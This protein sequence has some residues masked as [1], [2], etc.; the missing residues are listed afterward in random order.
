MPHRISKLIF[1][2]LLGK[3]LPTTEGVITIHGPERPIR[4]DRDRYGIPHIAAETDA[5]AWFALGFCQGQDR[6]FQI[7]ALVRVV[8]GTMSELIGTDMVPLDRLSRRIGFK[9]AAAA[10]WQLI[11][12]DDR[13]GLSAFAAGVNAGRDDGA[14]AKAHE[15]TLLRGG[16]TTFEATDVLAILALQAFA[17]AANW[18]AELARFEIL[19]GDGE[20]ALHKVDPKYPEWHP[21]TRSPDGMAGV[22]VDGLRA[23]LEL[24]REV[25]GL[26][27]ASN[28]WAI[29]GSRTTTGRPILANDPHLSPLLPPHWYL[30]HVSGVDWGVAG[31]CFAGTPGFASAH[32]GKVAWGVTAGLV[33]NTDLFIE[34]IGPDGASVQRGDDFVPCTV[35]EE[36][37]AVRGGDPVTEE[38]LMTP[39]G[40]IVGPALPGAH[41]AISMAATWLRPQ[42]ATSLLDIA[43]A[44]SVDE[45][46]DRLFGWN[47]PSLNFVAADDAGSIGWQLAGEAPVR[48]AGRG[49]LPLPAWLDGVGWE[50]AYVPYADMPSSHDPERGY[51]ATANTRPTTDDHPF[52]GVDWI[53]GYR[54]S[55]IN[56]ILAGRDDWDVVSTLQAQL[57]TVTHAWRDLKDHLLAIGHTA[58]TTAALSLLRSWDGDMSSESKAA[59]VFVIWLTDMQRRVAQV[60]APNSVDAA[61]GRGFAPAPLAPYSLFAFSRTGHLARLLRDRPEGW[62]DNWD[63]AIRASLEAAEKAL[64][65]KSGPTPRS[66]EWGTVRPLTL[67]HPAG[68]RKPLD[69]VFNVGPIPWS[70]DF[71]TVSQAGAPPLDPFG[72]PSAI[73]SLRMAVDVGDWDRSRFSLPGGQ[74]GNPLSPHYADQLDSWRLG[75]G[76][77][78]PWTEGAVAKGTAHT[79]YLTPLSS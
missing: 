46:R 52:L 5:D 39:H 62:F 70:G 8:R 16:A 13:I 45:L 68:Q 30:A 38:V 77:P 3:R 11:E 25:S 17:L 67:M 74:S 15:Y 44:G 55:R 69:R 76:V 37:I 9:R 65:E 10:S 78:M 24:L 60:A 4:I 26:G 22:P 73:A 19:T 54:L 48:K 36:H 42:R 40:P 63:E 31:A 2:T 75:L 53:E 7:E 29:S 47:G 6:S 58:E 79:L 41:E 71:T 59:S 72:N 34:E 18:D 1:Q 43:T 50:D 28:N 32:N 35:I 23:G 49:A 20:E 27:G 64:R 57:D 61:L 21:V 56:E 51:L 12:A 66:W 33:D 14:E